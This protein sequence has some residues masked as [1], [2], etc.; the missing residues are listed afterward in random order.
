[1]AIATAEMDTSHSGFLEFGI[2]DRD[3]YNSTVPFQWGGRNFIAARVESR[4]SERDSRV[5]FF[6]QTK[7]NRFL[8]CNA[9]PEFQM[10]DPFVK[11]IQGKLI[12]G[13]VRIDW[14]TCKW[15]TVIYV[16]E[17]FPKLEPLVA[18]PVG[19]KDI[20][21]V[22]TISGKVGVYT[23]PQGETEALGG[24]GK[25]G[26]TEIDDLSHLTKEV[27]SEAPLIPDT[28]GKEKWGGVN[29]AYLLPSGN[30][31]L[32]V[33]E[34][35][36][37]PDESKEYKAV[38]MIHN[39]KTGEVYNYQVLAQRSDFPPGPCKREG[40]ADVVFPGGLVIRGSYAILYT[41]L[42][43]ACVGR[44]IIRNPF[45]SEMVSPTVQKPLYA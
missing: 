4:D 28:F 23:R 43:D 22:E 16:S 37:K 19:M 21:L 20:R 36:F 12:F 41:G 30:H 24:K 10:Q 2:S 5:F 40:L 11:V 6:E 42:S 39:P 32:L 38:A 18:G 45:M 9:L 8:P 29:D 44:L 3:V 1:M 25:I 31:G 17:R 15:R 14:E 34:A 26:Y 35:R 33:H 27:I 7:E 13:G